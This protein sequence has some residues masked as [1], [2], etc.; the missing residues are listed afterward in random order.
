[1][2]TTDYFPISTSL[3]NDSDTK[4]ETEET[5]SSFSSPKPRLPSAGASYTKPK[6]EIETPAQE[7]LPSFI[8]DLLESA[9]ER[10]RQEARIKEDKPTRSY[11]RKSSTSIDLDYRP[12]SRKAAPVLFCQAHVLG[13]EDFMRASLYVE[14]KSL[15]PLVLANG[16]GKYISQGLS[17][18]SAF[19]N[20]RR[21]A[22]LRLKPVSAGKEGNRYSLPE[23]S[24]TYTPGLPSTRDRIRIHEA[25]LAA[26]KIARY[27]GIEGE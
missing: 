8:V 10:A 5:S 27:Y 25:R 16:G 12:E 14:N 26:E 6:E 2:L 23:G 20:L 9:K 7:E 21:E 17:F 4:I 18:A 1:M 22:Q 3:T 19:D 15:R 24:K 11:T 13:D